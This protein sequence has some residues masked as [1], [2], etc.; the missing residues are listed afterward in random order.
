METLLPVNGDGSIHMK[1]EIWSVIAHDPTVHAKSHD[2]RT[3]AA[4]KRIFEGSLCHWQFVFVTFL[5]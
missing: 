4:T 3:E 5:V 2:L 1:G